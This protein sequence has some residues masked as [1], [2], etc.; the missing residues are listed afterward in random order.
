MSR[1]KEPKQQVWEERDSRDEEDTSLHLIRGLRIIL[2]ILL[3]LILACVIWIAPITL[4][5]VRLIL[6]ILAVAVIVLFF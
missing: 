6:T 1:I 3:F 2:S 5:W 4:W